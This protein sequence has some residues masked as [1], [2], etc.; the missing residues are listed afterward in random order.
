MPRIARKDYHTNFFHIIVQ[1]INKEYIFNKK[2][3]IEKYLYLLDVNAKKFEFKI[4]AYCVMNNHV[5]ILAY[6]E[7][8]ENMAKVMQKTNTSYGIFYNKEEDRVGYVFR[9][10]YYTQAILTEEQ[11]LRCLVY[12]HNNPIRAEMVENIN[13]YKYSSYNNYIYKTGNVTD[14]IIKLIFGSCYK[15]LEMFKA[16]HNNIDVKELNDIVEED[17]DYQNIL[18]EYEMKTKKS[19]EEI[20]LNNAN[21]KAL[22]KYLKD[23]FELSQRDISKILNINK[24]KVNRILKSGIFKERP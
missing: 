10:R 13:Q 11:L 23:E 3:Y 17:I 9:N 4:I 19:L 15:Y 2:E 16:I 6:T 5:H 20:K 21:L 12:I 1:G 14:E 7:K 18:N 8:I 22:I 24:N